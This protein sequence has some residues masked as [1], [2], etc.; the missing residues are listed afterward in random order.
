MLICHLFIFGD[1]S[2][3]IVYPFFNCVGFFFS[4]LSFGRSF[5]FW[6]Q[7]FYGTYD[8]KIFSSRLWF[9]F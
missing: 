1:V 8:L 4:I 6:V 2:V 7:A 9:A 5:V 3:Q